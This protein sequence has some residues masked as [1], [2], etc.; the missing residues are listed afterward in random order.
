MN[1]VPLR[2]LEEFIFELVS[3]LKEQIKR[4]DRND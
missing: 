3:A 2:K 4:D 1:K